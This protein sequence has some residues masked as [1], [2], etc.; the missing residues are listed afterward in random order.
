MAEKPVHITD[1]HKVLVS[2]VDRALAPGN[3]FAKRAKE[4]ATL[5]NGETEDGVAENVR[6]VA[7]LAES[8][9]PVETHRESM[10]KSPQAFANALAKDVSNTVRAEAQELAKK[11]VK[12][13]E[14]RGSKLAHGLK[15]RYEKEARELRGI[16]STVLVHNAHE[17]RSLVKSKLIQAVLD[18][19]NED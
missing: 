18:R 2:Y 12:E 10:M 15:L 8:A 1:L 9:K 17:L 16:I 6:R 7:E 11:A 14:A 3:K 4:V 5:V 19:E 13:G